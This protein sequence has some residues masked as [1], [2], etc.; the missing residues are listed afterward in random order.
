KQRGKL[1]L[2]RRTVPFGPP[3]GGPS[4]APTFRVGLVR[5]QD[6]GA[7]IDVELVPGLFERGRR[8]AE[9]SARG[10]PHD[11]VLHK[12]VDGDE[13]ADM[14]AH[15]LLHRVAGLEVGTDVRPGDNAAAAPDS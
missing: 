9:T 3:G 8:G 12:G 10:R 11:P 6:A 14:V 4:L 7:R 1:A 13:V 2:A 15:V 5:P